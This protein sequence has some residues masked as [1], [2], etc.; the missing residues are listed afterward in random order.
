MP[1]AKSKGK[2]ESVDIE[3]L[4]ATNKPDKVEPA[5]KTQD[6]KIILA[7]GRPQGEAFD[8]ANGNKRIDH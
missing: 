6:G 5:K 3:S 2:E 7:H 1:K 4:P 8:T